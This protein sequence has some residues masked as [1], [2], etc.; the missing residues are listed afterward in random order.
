MLVALYRSSM[1]IPRLRQFLARLMYWFFARRFPH[2]EWR[3]MN[4]GSAPS[5]PRESWFPLETADEAD[6]YF[7]G[8]YRLL[9]SS[10]L[11]PPR[12]RR[13]P[14]RQPPRGRGPG[15]AGNAV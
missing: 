13:A 6:R 14:E 9:A 4:Y 3:F 15:A 1:R 5:G 8:P 11:R 2:G 10:V 7:I 12:E